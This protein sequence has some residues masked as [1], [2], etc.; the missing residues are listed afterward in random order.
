MTF[1]SRKAA[2]LKVNGSVHEPCYCL[3]GLLFFAYLSREDY[4][5]RLTHVESNW[6]VDKFDLGEHV[7]KHSVVAD[8]QSD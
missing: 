3:P 8:L 1:D 7:V 4:T 2:A 6:N 5:A